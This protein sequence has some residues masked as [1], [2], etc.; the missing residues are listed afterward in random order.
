[1]RPLR[2]RE[3]RYWYRTLGDTAQ[4]CDSVAGTAAAPDL[5]TTTLDEFHVT[6]EIDVFDSDSPQYANQ[7]WPYLEDIY[8][9]RV[10]WSC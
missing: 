1:M 10:L 2:L 5:G 7:S 3:E 9:T 4:R 6:V 8:A